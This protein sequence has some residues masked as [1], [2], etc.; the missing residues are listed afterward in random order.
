M[1]VKDLKK[2]LPSLTAFR[3][4]ML[5]ETDLLVLRPGKLYTG[6]VEHRY[7]VLFDHGVDASIDFARF[8]KIIMALDPLD[9]VGFKYSEEKQEV[10]IKV[11]QVIQF[12]FPVT[13][14][15]INYPEMLEENYS[16]HV[17][18][19]STGI[20][21][22][23]E[24]SLEFVSSDE[25][26]PAMT[27]V[28]FADQ[29]LVSTDANR[30]YFERAPGIHPERVKVLETRMDE[31]R[32]SQTGMSLSELSEEEKEELTIREVKPRQGIILAKSVCAALVRIKE[33]LE[34]FVF[35]SY[36]ARNHEGEEYGPF[37]PW[38]LLRGEGF[39]ITTRP[40][41]ERFPDFRSV[42][43]DFEKTDHLEMIAPTREMLKN[44]KLAQVMANPVTFL[45][46]FRFNPKTDTM[47]RIFAEDL[48]YS[49]RFIRD[50]EA[51]REIVLAPQE[52]GSSEKS[53]EWFGAIGFNAR[54]LISIL[55]LI[56]TP[57]TSFKFSEPS[58][59]A[60]INGKYLLM[61]VMIHKYL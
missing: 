48:D 40:I 56:D 34:F 37:S 50:V 12:S 16:V 60:I 52:S 18:T 47:V 5:P 15:G 55:K 54:L 53:M 21:E 8:K 29:T 9:E 27:G 4:P 36:P 41:D 58:R 19:L 39:E 28:C 3:S 45:T 11:N 61:P 44:V 6:C 7:S 49:T 42:I 22:S 23:V 24:E 14:G 35:D 51:S 43:P 1:K 46:E 32:L 30:M 26:R 57:F 59:P 31:E 13:E 38:A 10:Y 2:H 25:L 17:G 20:L 33:P